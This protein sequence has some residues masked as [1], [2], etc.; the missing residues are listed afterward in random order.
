M[1]EDATYG[2][3]FPNRLTELAKVAATI[4]TILEEKAI[5]LKTAYTVNLAVEEV[6]TNII[7]YGFD[8]NAEHFITLHLT[9][10][11]DA[12]EIRMEDDGREFDP[13]ALNPPDIEIPVE[14]RP[15]GGLGIHLVRQTVDNITYRREAGKNILTIHID[16][17]QNR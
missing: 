12:I 4:E 3:T 10:G 13:L 7:N 2:F 15:V 17:T 14:Q 11:I 5:P 8:D 16:Y 1:N 6:A 9:M